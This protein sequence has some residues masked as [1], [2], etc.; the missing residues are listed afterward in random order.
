MD[1]RIDVSKH[2]EF[3]K[4]DKVGEKGNVKKPDGLVTDNDV[5]RLSDKELDELIKVVDKS[6][7]GKEDAES[8]KL[9]IEFMKMFNSPEMQ[10]RLDAMINNQITKM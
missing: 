5:V 10:K 2:P 3:K 6:N 4:F 1:F 8:I 7:I 9:T